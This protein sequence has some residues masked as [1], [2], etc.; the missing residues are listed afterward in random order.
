V[1][2]EIFELHPYVL[3][4][5]G[6]G[7]ALEA[8]ASHLRS[9]SGPTIT[10][11]APA[12]V[13]PANSDLLVAIARELVVNSIRHA[14]ADRVELVVRD[15]PAGLVLEVADDGRGLREEERLA[16]LH[17]GHIGLA[18]V[19]ERVRALDGRLDVEGVPGGGTRVRVT[20]PR[21]VS[22]WT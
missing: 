9:P 6:L 20:L 10:V 21:T 2:G 5:A 18:L 4:H 3:E 15:E 12:G 17:D 22:V 7:A 1:R 14:A 19:T 8:M 13:D 16:A 11:R